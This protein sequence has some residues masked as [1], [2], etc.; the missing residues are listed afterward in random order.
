MLWAVWVAV[1]LFPA[2]AGVIPN[3]RSVIILSV[4]VPRASGG[5][6]MDK[7]GVE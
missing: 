3:E 2:R 1:E 4:A 6:P 5:D 7:G